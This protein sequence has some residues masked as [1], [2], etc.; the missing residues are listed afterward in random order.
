[1][2]FPLHCVPP[3]SFLVS[4]SF[5]SF[6]KGARAVHRAVAQRRAGAHHGVGHG[7]S[8]RRVGAAVARRA[9]RRQSQVG[10]IGRGERGAQQPEQPGQS[11]PQRGAGVGPRPHHRSGRALLP[12]AAARTRLLPRVKLK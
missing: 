4:F 7:H 1:M 10:P 9:R 6:F 2:Q 3:P 5:S 12:G 8:P 11:R